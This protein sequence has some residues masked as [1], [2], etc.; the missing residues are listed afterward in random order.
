MIMMIMNMISIKAFDL[1]NKT[2]AA[3]VLHGMAWTVMRDD[4]L[5]HDDDHDHDDH[6]YDFKVFDRQACCGVAWPVQ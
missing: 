1:I 3:L 4:D 6:Y 2:A 5:E